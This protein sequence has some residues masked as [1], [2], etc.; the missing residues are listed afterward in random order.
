MTTKVDTKTSGCSTL[1]LLLLLVGILLNLFSGQDDKKVQEIREVS[2]SSSSSMKSDNDRTIEELFEIMG[3]SLSDYND[4]SSDTSRVDY[5]FESKEITGNYQNLLVNNLNFVFEDTSIDVKTIFEK[6]GRPD[7]IW[8]DK[9]YVYRSEGNYEIE[10]WWNETQDTSAH[11]S[12]YIKM[13]WPIDGLEGTKNVFGVPAGLPDDISLH[14]S[15]V[16]LGEF[17]GV[18]SE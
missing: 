16:E 8:I 3:L 5:M 4:L 9:S 6:L 14:G 12:D 18:S 1:I 11:N 15:I 2:Q 10:A 17:K 7:T 13:E